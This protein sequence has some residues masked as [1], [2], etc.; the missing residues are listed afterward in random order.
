MPG[1]GVFV[2][3]SGQK[4]VIPLENNPEVFTALAHDLGLSSELSFYDVYSVDEPDLL[5]LIPRPAHALIFITPAKMYYESRKEDDIASDITDPSFNKAGDDP[6]MWFLQTIGNACG[7]YALL[8]STA[9]GSARSF[10]NKGSFL[11]KLLTE[12]T[13]LKT[14]ERA[15]S[16]Y[17]NQE[18]EDKHMHAARTGNTQAPPAEDHPGHHF[19]AYVK[20]KDGHLWE[21]EGNTDGPVDRGLIGDDDDVLSEAALKQGVKK[22]L[23][24]SNGALNFS[25]IALAPKAE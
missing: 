18:L 3:P 7:L 9:N 11:D 21:L 13:T 2:T 23:K 10:V 1:E 14:K 22:F 15:E 20:G 24:Y 8:H 16:V 4:M 25:L 6:V 17:N 12:V 5:A 19:I